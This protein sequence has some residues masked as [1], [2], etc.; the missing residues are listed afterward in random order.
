LESE[1]LPQ[2]AFSHHFSPVAIGIGVG[3]DLIEKIDFD[4][5]DVSNEAR[6]MT[7]RVYYT[8]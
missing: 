3:I 7:C 8:M 5:E 6:D 2:S 1:R 4:G